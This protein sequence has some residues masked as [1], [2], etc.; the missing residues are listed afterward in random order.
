MSSTRL[1]GK[2]LKTLLGKPMLYRQIERI[3][4][5]KR[6]DDLIIA[7]STS[8]D[9]DQIERLCSEINVKCFRGSLDDVLDRFYKAALPY[10]PDFI[11]RL[12][13]DCPLFD[14]SLA[15][16]LIDFFLKGGYDYA[17]NTIEPTY[18]DGLDIEIM[19]FS[20]LETTWKEAVLPSDR[21]H[22]TPYIRKNA[23]KFKLG[24]MKYDVDLSYMRWT[25]D[26]PED[27]L[28]ITQ[29]FSALYPEKPDFSWNEVL[30][31]IKANPA[32]ADL[33]SGFKRNEGYQKS[34]LNDKKI[35]YQY[36]GI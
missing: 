32:I 21:E 5:S 11:I 2:V 28:F 33:N 10:K 18:P 24:C 7:T 9:D 19:K 35:S 17:S 12:T 23:D 6:I 27:Y 26:E 16:E 3:L 14:H 1:P 34:L 29:V 22:V 8:G 25:V 4:K 15:D 36:K 13:G 20:A 31:F 30:E